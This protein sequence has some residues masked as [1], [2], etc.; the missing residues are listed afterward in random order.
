MSK[1]VELK[2]VGTKELRRNTSDGIRSY[3]KATRIHVFATGDVL[4][5][6]LSRND[7]RPITK[8]REAI[9]KHMPEL[10]DS[11]MRWSRT[12]GCYC[13]CS[14]GFILNHTRK[15]D[16]QPTDLYLDIACEPA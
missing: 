4:T 13:G 6:L 8:Y 3:N 16:G 5:N 2:I 7:K 1:N 14:P 12:A 15:L 10:A 11:Q 9:L